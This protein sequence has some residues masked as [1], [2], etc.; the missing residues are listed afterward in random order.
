V[1]E[2]IKMVAES[3]K[4]NAQVLE[5][6][7]KKLEEVETVIYSK[8]KLNENKL[9]RRMDEVSSNCFKALDAAGKINV[10]SK[11]L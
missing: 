8:I 4:D 5:N 2:E 10:F 9:E 6:Y 7:N 11:I 1:Q 3:L